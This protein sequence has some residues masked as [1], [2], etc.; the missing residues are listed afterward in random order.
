MDNAVRQGQTISIATYHQQGG[1]AAFGSTVGA[2]HTGAVGAPIDQPAAD[3]AAVMQIVTSAGDIP[4]Q[5]FTAITSA[6]LELR[7]AVAGGDDARAAVDQSRQLIADLTRT[8]SSTN[9]AAWALLT[10]AGDYAA[11]RLTAAQ[12]TG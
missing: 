5:F 6:Q 9:Q 7:A 3:L 10:A 2:Q 1:S 8:A 11:Q 4:A 12:V